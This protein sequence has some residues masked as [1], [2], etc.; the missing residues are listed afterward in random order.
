F[1]PNLHSIT[2]LEATDIASAASGKAG[3]LLALWA[4][5][6][7]I[8]PLSYKL[9]EQ[10]AT[11]HNGENRWGYRKL[12]CIQIWTKARQIKPITIKATDQS[13]LPKTDPKFSNAKSGLPE[14][15]DWFVTEDI[16]SYSKLGDTSNTAQVHPYQFTTAMA[17]LAVERGVIIKFGLV[18]NIEKS[19]GLVSS[20]TFKNNESGKIEHITATDVIL[21]AGPWSSNLFPEI[22][23]EVARTHSVTIQA[24]VSPY[25]VFSEIKVPAGF[26]NNRRQQGKNVSIELYPRPNGEVYACGERD[27]SV[28]LPETSALVECD[29]SI[30]QDVI[31]CIGSISDEM[32][33]GKVLVRQA[34]YLPII[35]ESEGDPLIGPTAIKGL[36]IATGHSWWGI[37]NSCAT[38]LLMSEFIFDGKAISANIDELDP[39]RYFSTH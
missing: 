25:A 6:L 16:R 14:D 34:C 31:D 37:Q 13:K 12:P 7:S 3:G 20:V 28:P 30:C 22:Q 24:D 8:V 2:I 18:T 26:G 9:H 35:A 4:S 11:E 15:L 38:G 10:L 29:E 33:N 32:R 1:N 5:P 27:Y 36:F 39:R 19:G 23:F 17:E 21:S